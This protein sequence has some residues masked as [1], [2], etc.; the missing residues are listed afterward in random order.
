ML[1]CASMG[2][3]VFVVQQIYTVHVHVLVGFMCLLC[4]VCERYVH[5]QNIL[6]GKLQSVT[7]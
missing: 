1:E 6:L 4:T 2:R 7:L 5:V 3:S